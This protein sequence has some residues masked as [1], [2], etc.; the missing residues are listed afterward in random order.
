MKKIKKIYLILL[1]NMIVISVFSISFLASVRNLLYPPLLPI[2]TPTA[3]IY[4]ELSEELEG[5]STF[6][7]NRD[8]KKKIENKDVLL[9]VDSAY[10]GIGIYDPKGKLSGISDTEGK[11]IDLREERAVY[12]NNNIKSNE[13]YPLEKFENMK[14][15]KVKG[16]FDGNNPDFDYDKEFI[17]NFFSDEYIPNYYY[18]SGSRE[19]IDEVVNYLENSKLEFQIN[20]YPGANISSVLTLIFRDFRII[21]SFIAMFLSYMAIYNFFKESYRN[22]KR[23]Y[24]I[25]KLHGI[26]RLRYVNKKLIYSNIYIFLLSFISLGIFLKETLAYKSFWAYGIFMLI[27]NLI[28]VL[29]LNYISI[30]RCIKEF[31]EDKI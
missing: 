21:L 8:L 29:I 12:F 27:F 1:F 24:F 6:S 31:E 14:N 18:L 11:A 28:F 25:I 20:F 23:E 4:I 5:I 2:E 9:V 19:V 26:N 13:F 7:F 30:N 17:Y 15:F 10:A 3:E 22:L 16:F